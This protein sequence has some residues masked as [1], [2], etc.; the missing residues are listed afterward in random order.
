MGRVL[1]TLAALAVLVVAGSAVA[2]PAVGPRPRPDVGPID[3]AM[4][5]DGDVSVP[6]GP[7]G[8]GAIAGTMPFTYLRT[9]I[10]NSDFSQLGGILAPHVHE[11]VRGS[12]GFFVGAFA[13]DNWTYGIHMRDGLWCFLP[14]KVGNP[15]ESL[16]VILS[17]AVS[18]VVKNSNPYWID[19]GIISDGP[20]GQLMREVEI[21]PQPVMIADHPHLQYR[22]LGWTTNGARA[23]FLVNDRLVGQ[24]DV[25]AEADGSVHLGLIGRSY[26]RLTHD[27]ANPA[28]ADASFVPTGARMT[29]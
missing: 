25:G 12:P 29:G 15:H 5:Q 3:Q 19:R 1:R 14:S 23:E 27:E 8:P 4:R 7:V 26:L 17:G 11:V 10:L 13:F 16:C 21:D 18:L 2:G 24:Y 22:F 9:G 28:A 20:H 6:T